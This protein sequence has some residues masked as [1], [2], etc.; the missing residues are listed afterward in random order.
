MC[1]AVRVPWGEAA[2]F[3]LHRFRSAALCCEVLVT[4]VR[5]AVQHLLAHLARAHFM[6]MYVALLAVLARL[7]VIY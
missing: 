1:R 5:K 3:L 4:A 2:V 6:K 7:Q